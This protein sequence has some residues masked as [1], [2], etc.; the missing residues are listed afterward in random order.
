MADDGPDRILGG[1]PRIPTASNHR[2]HLRSQVGVDEGVHHGRRLLHCP[3]VD[4]FLLRDLPNRQHGAGRLS[5]CRS[6]IRH[7]RDHRLSQRHTHP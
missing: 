7:T 4:L 3:H 1:H 5:A 2:P 6:R